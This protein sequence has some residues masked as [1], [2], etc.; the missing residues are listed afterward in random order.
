MSN[1]DTITKEYDNKAVRADVKKNI[2]VT[3]GAGFIGSHLVGKLLAQG[4][5]VIVL[6]IQ[7]MTATMQFFADHYTRTFAYMQCD[8][9][10]NVPVYK[11]IDEIYHL[12]GAI[13]TK[14]I[15]NSAFDVLFIN[16]AMM[17][18]LVNTYQGRVKKIVFTSTAEVYTGQEVPMPT[19]E[20]VKIGWNDTSDARWAYSM[21]KF[22]CEQLLRS[23]KPGTFD[24]S[25]ARL[26]NVYG[27]AM[28]Q[29]YVVKAFIRRLHEAVP[30][31]HIS[32]KSARDTRPLTY[33][34][35]TIEALQRMMDR[36]EANGQIINIGN[37]NSIEILEL[38]KI[39][40]DIMNKDVMLSYQTGDNSPKPEL[41]LPNFNKA[42]VLLDW[43]AQVD[44]R[45]G[46]DY[47]IAWYK[48]YGL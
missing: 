42:Y 8:L 19:D 35:D 43:R 4:H 40:K 23:F 5:E 10:Y 48:E 26:S 32:I 13:G 21:A 15:I 9:V 7:P 18:N 1:Q 12:A 22:Y 38:A 2:I 27:P 30:K 33:V 28:Q 45:E 41:R 14:E 25:I 34:N 11:E 29:D 6:D 20:K 3:G 36:K 44:I 39:M 17:R 24:W 46:L 31:E 47:T 37:S 16:I